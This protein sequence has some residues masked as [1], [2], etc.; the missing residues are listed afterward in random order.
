MC[1]DDLV[2]K[3]VFISRFLIKWGVAGKSGLRSSLANFAP[4]NILKLWKAPLLYIMLTIPANIAI[5]M[6]SQAHNK[7]PQPT[8]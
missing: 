6:D 4:S 1:N 5:K 2:G 8:F 7:C 3:I